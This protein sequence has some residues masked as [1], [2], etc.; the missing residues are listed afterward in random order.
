MPKENIKKKKK[1]LRKLDI[2]IHDTVARI[3]EWSQYLK[4]ITW[5]KWNPITIKLNSRQQENHFLTS[6][7]EQLA[8]IL[9]SIIKEKYEAYLLQSIQCLDS[10]PSQDSFI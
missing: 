1:G 5:Y 7:N 2:R 4:I 9:L 8:K 6:K 10:S 3:S